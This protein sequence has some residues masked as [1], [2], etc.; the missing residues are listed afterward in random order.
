M[1]FAGPA[2]II[3]LNYL[4]SFNVIHSGAPVWAS[5]PVAVR[6][7]AIWVGGVKEKA[8][9]VVAP[10]DITSIHVSL[11]YQNKVDATIIPFLNKLKETQ[12]PNDNTVNK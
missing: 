1:K 7:W 11:L 9:A 8:Q 4:P 5:G 3:P 6:A 2:N 12:M 10:H